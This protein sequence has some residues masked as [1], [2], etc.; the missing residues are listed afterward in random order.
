VNKN[1]L[2][3]DYFENFGGGERLVLSIKKLFPQLITSFINEDIKKKIKFSKVNLI[4]DSK[5]FNILKKINLINNFKKI[6]I[7]NCDNL[8]CSGNYSIFVNL[9]ETKNT[10]VYIHSM[11]KI[12]FRANDFYKK[13]KLLKKLFN[14][15]FRN[16]GKEYIS[17]IKKFDKIIVN[18]R[19]TKKIVK[20]YIKKKI[21]VIYPPIEK[22]IF[23][24]K[25]GE[26][27]FSNNRHE[28]EKNI[29]II[30]K[31]FSELNDK[32]L[33]LSSKGSQT[34]RLKKLSQN[35]KN[36]KFVGVL[37]NK[38]YHKYLSKCIATI[39]ISSKEDFGMAALEGMV[40]GKPT[41]CMKEGGYLETTKDKINAIHI[42]KYNIFN[43]LKRKIKFY[44]RDKLSSMAKN[45][46][47][48][49]NSFSEKKFQSKIKKLLIS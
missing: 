41:F 37:S 17:S 13:N 4:D 30:I 38:N 28:N 49:A 9:N 43:D 12:Y 2:I 15:K 1:I 31:V 3:H 11:P 40:Y 46:K 34:K 48:T 32:K 39:N 47:L 42:N 29:D 7:K 8:L 24:E 45:C 16:Y 36:I 44:K 14:I 6:E 27:Y 33:I 22:K 19:F 20:K 21:Q 25:S 35:F 26:Y 5:K 23:K 18:S 10:I